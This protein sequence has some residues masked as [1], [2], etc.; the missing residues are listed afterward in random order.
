[1]P[2]NLLLPDQSAIE[3]LTTTRLDISIVIVNYNVKYFLDQVL[4]SV[5]QAS[6]NLDVEVFVVDNNSVDGSCEMVLEKYPEVNLIASEINLG[7]SKGN[8]LA[9]KQCKGRYVLLL[10]PDTIIEE[11]TLD[12]VVGFM[13]KHPEA[14]SLGVRMIDGK[15]EFLPESKRGLPTPS[16]AL[17]KLLG[18]SKMFPR[19]KRFGRYHQGFLD[20]HGV[21]EIDVVSGAFMLIRKEVLDEVGLLDETFFM[22]GEDID[23]SYRIKKAGHK[24]YYFPE[25]SII[26][27]KGEST[28]KK[29][30]NYVKVFYGAM[31]I[32]VKKHYSGNYA[33]LMSLLLNLA[34]TVI[35]LL[36]IFKRWLVKLLWPIIDFTLLYVGFIAIAKYWEHYN[37]WVQAIYPFEYYAYHIPLYI[38]VLMAAV[39]LSGGYDKPVSAKRIFRGLFFGAVVLFG[40]YGF[41][42]KSFQFSRAIVGLGAAWSFIAYLLSRAAF[43]FVQF[44]NLDIGK[45]AK[46]NTILVGQSSELENYWR[47]IKQARPSKDLIGVVTVGHE[48]DSE[49][50]RHLGDIRN[51]EEI[52]E[53]YQVNEVLFCSDDLSM[54][55]I[56]STMSILKSQDVKFRIIGRD[57]LFV[58]GSDS[59]NEP[60]HWLS[61]EV[62]LNISTPNILRKK[63]IVDLS[64]CAIL[65]AVFPIF[66]VRGSLSKWVK[67][68]VQVLS[69]NKFWVSVDKSTDESFKG[70]KGGIF[71]PKDRFPDYTL[72]SK[73]LRNIN[74]DYAKN[75]D[76]LVDVEI[77]VKN[78]FN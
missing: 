57:G 72:E 64:L 31:L 19:S 21:H 68:W 75:M 77:V 37:K 34:I 55:K 70:I 15:G 11:D 44:G 48:Q 59:K 23:L 50:Q 66:L 24:N 17:Y 60:G 36:A 10:N 5:R 78:L 33:G 53:I 26:H 25:T 3:P 32:F 69:G 51:I 76:L 28:K 67:R 22:Y 61:K 46:T 58:L 39:F 20:E 16:V 14:G 18:L 65:V 13:N 62:S 30:A 4:T 7:F 56:I 40:L 42:S 74:L 9:I 38:I 41:M 52:I 2:M 8:N 27:F 54:S 49:K 63:R 71:T 45:K 73:A 35:A 47:A 29:S 1:M 6:S 12:K 43:Q